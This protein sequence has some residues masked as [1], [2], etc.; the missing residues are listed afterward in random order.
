MSSAY[1]KSVDLLL[2]YAAAT[3]PCI[4]HEADVMHGKIVHM[5]QLDS[6]NIS[7]RWVG[8]LVQELAGKAAYLSFFRAISTRSSMPVHWLK[9]MTLSP[10]ADI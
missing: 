1:H 2:M 6:K 5:V 9:T 3:V 7:F 10:A 4:K 8:I